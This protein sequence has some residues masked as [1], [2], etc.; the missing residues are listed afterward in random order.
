MGYKLPNYVWQGDGWHQNGY[1]WTA[2]RKLYK[3]TVTQGPRCY[4]PH[5]WITSGHYQTTTSYTPL[6][7]YKTIMVPT[8]T[9]VSAQG[10]HI[11]SAQLEGVLPGIQD[12]TPGSPYDGQEYWAGDAATDGGFCDGGTTPLISP[13]NPDFPDYSG[14]LSAYTAYFESKNISTFN[15]TLIQGNNVQTWQLN[16]DH[17]A[18]LLRAK[19]QVTV[20]YTLTT[21]VNGKVTSQVPQTQTQD[22]WSPVYTGPTWPIYAVTGVSCTVNN[23]MEYCPGHAPFPADSG[24]YAF[25]SGADG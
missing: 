25:S 24:T 17:A 6:V 5:R 22:V 23:G 3:F 8:V 12:V 15:P 4:Y 2:I 21:T 1:N 9:T 16:G 7:T 13:S 10:L 18:L 14:D 19:Y 20:S 11:S